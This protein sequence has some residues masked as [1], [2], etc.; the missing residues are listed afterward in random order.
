[1]VDKELL[2]QY[3]DLT[4][5]IKELEIRI[6]NIKNKKIK[7]ERDSVTGSN[8][9]FPYNMQNFNIEGYNF[10]EADK[11]EARIIKLN[12]L[13]CRRKCK[14]EDLKLEIEEFISSIPDSLTRRVFQYRYIDELGWLQIAMRIGKYEESYPRKIIHDKY[15]EQSE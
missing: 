12:N 11:R 10:E 5:E 13:L 7:I 9:Y 4:V 1:M 15:L 3:S 6:N 14:C 8:P 2:R